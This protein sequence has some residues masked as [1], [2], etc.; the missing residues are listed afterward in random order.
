MFN[1]GTLVRAARIPVLFLVLVAGILSGCKSQQEKAL[2]QA[3]A[4]AAKTG[5]PQQVVSVDKNGTTTTTVVQPPPAGQTNQVISTTQTPVAV[6]APV[7]KPSGPTISAVPQ[8]VNVTIQSGT[9]LT[10]RIDQRISVKASR[11]GDT[12]TG[13]LVNPVLAEDNRV[14]LPKGAFLDS[15]PPRIS[16]CR[17]PRS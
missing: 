7:P 13:E 16:R 12:F 4:Q 2:D 10:I 6:G 14:L 3:K 9:T 1:L 11:S 8:P 5:Q 17:S 15:P